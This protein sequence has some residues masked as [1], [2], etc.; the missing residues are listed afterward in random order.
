MRIEDQA[1]LEERAEALA[2]RITPGEDD[3]DYA[4]SPTHAERPLSPS[5]AAEKLAPKQ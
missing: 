1:E 4:L 5:R 3:I 2:R